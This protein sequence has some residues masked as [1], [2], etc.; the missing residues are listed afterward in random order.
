MIKQTQRR[1]MNDL[2]VAALLQTLGLAATGVGV[3]LFIGWLASQA[4]N[5]ARREAARQLAIRNSKRFR[6]RRR[7]TS[8]SSDLKIKDPEPATIESKIR[9]VARMSGS[10][11]QLNG[12]I[13]AEL[14]LQRIETERLKKEAT[15][16]QEVS[17]MN[18]EALAAARTLVQSELQTVLKVNGKADRRFQVIVAAIS[19]ALGVGATILLQSLTGG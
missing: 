16:A 7:S 1:N 4:R 14:D 8:I 2:A 10:I 18:A 6:R 5:N 13:Q 17:A 9:D 12:E 15:T 11:S 19:F 3:S